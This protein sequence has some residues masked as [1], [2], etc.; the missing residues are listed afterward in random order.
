MNWQ[1]RK[2][3][4]PNQSD[5]INCGIFVLKFSESLMQNSTNMD[6]NLT[7]NFP[8]APS[9]LSNFR[10]NLIKYFEEH[11]GNFIHKSYL[12]FLQIV[13]SLLKSLVSDT[14]YC[15]QCGDY[16]LRG[17]TTNW[18]SCDKCSKWYHTSCAAIKQKNLAS[19][20][21]ECFICKNV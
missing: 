5:S 11:S 4:H 8:T 20:S 9:D 18:I 6:N 15:T 19:F 10:Q 21:Y 7:F 12:H 17:K 13:I 2:I 16:N 1:L 3:T 14:E